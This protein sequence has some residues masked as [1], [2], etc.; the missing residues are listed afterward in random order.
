MISV[1]QQI[2]Y[3]KRNTYMEYET[4]SFV[5][6]QK[7]LPLFANAHLC[8]KDDMRHQPNFSYENATSKIYNV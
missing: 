5:A 7:A 2:K 6:I 8:N 4:Y 3:I 1:N